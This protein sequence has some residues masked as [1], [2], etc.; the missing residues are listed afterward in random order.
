MLLKKNH[1]AV[2]ICSIMLTHHICYN[3]ELTPPN[4]EMTQALQKQQAPQSQKKLDLDLVSL[5]DDAY[6]EIAS[7]LSW[8][9]ILRTSLG[10]SELNSHFNDPSRPI[11]LDYS[12]KRKQHKIQP[13]FNSV[14]AQL[15]AIHDHSKYRKNPISL[16]LRTNRLAETPAFRCFGTFLNQL[17]QTQEQTRDE[18]ISDHIR[19][20]DLSFNAL[21]R[22]PRS[23]DNCAYLRELAFWGNKPEAVTEF[24]KRFPNL[25]KVMSQYL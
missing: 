18:P 9:D 5:P 17:K 19:T 4:V 22:I 21:I 6:H 24:P 8:S 16:L 13:F 3:M 15:Q 14:F 1:V 20:M 25:A 11:V 23:I 12:T 10:C 7:H 2:V